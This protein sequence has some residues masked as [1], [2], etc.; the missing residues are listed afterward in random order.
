MK[1]EGRRTFV[2]KIQNEFNKGKLIRPLIISILI[3]YLAVGSHAQVKEPPDT[4]AVSSGNLLLK[5]LLWH[6][7]GTG[8]FP[9]IIFCHG[10]YVTNGLRY[11]VVQ[12]TSVLG[13]LF[14][15]NDYVFLGLFRQ[16]TGLSKNQGKNSA[17]L[18]SKALKEKGQQERNKVQ[19]HQLQ[20]NDLQDISS[21]LAFLRQRKDV[22][23]N[24]IAVIGHS[25]G[26]SLALLVT[27]HDPDIKAVVVFGAAGFSWNRSPQLRIGLIEA[28]KKINVPVMLV[29]AQNDYSLDPAYSLDSAMT[30]SGKQH[31]L[32]IY[33]QYGKSSTEGHNIVFQDPDLWKEDVFKFL[34]Q[35]LH[36]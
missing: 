3:F 10:S 7:I 30:L 26:G 24:S 13:P 11:D 1:I 33:P 32:K 21:G 35:Y 17:D 29:Y 15:K 8:V 19:M 5:G 20:T 31:L 34:R 27:E 28:I 6:P 18:M 2:L 25:F 23:T 16:G 36:H 9:T 12:Q 14:A 4:V 22:D